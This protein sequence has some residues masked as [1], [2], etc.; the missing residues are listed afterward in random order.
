MVFHHLPGSGIKGVN[1]TYTLSV[2]EALR[3]T[4]LSSEFKTKTA[5][6][7]K[8]QAYSITAKNK[9]LFFFASKVFYSGSDIMEHR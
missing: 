7:F 9:D 4:E 8:I 2:D 3:N 6:A 1:Q 5:L